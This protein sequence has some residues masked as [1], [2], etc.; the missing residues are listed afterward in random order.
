METAE[1]PS[2]GGGVGGNYKG[3]NRSSSFIWFGQ[4]SRCFP[5]SIS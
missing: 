1:L 4:V 5:P 3:V 2:G